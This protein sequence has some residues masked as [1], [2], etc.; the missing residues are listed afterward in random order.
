MDLDTY[1]TIT[2]EITDYL[3]T[4]TTHFNIRSNLEV[5]ITNEYRNGTRSRF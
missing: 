1:E 2:Y 3:R 5:D 4:T